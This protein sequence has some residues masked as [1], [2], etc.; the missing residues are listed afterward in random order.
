MVL[1][2]QLSY[3]QFGALRNRTNTWSLVSSI[4]EDD[5]R[6]QEALCYSSCSESEGSPIFGLLSAIQCSTTRHVLRKCLGI[7]ACL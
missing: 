4:A 1:T 3:A 6:S 5:N 7:E 2:C